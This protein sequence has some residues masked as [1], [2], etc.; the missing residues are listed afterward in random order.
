LRERLDN[1]ALDA[2]QRLVRAAAPRPAVENIV[3]VGI[4]EETERRFPE[5]LALWHRH[6]GEALVAMASANPKLIAL[7]IVLPERSY[8]SLVPGLD[9]ELVRGLVA[10]KHAG[11]LV[12]G[13]RL[14][15]QGKPQVV[16]NLLLAAAGQEAMGLAYVTVD[17]D[18]TARRLKQVHTTTHDAKLPL[19]AQ[20]VASAIGLQTRDGIIDFACGKSF[21]YLPM[22]D[23]ISWVREQPLRLST[24]LEGKVVLLGKVG[25]D[26]DPVRQPLS[27]ADWAPN[28]AAPPGVVLIA[29]TLR[30]LESGRILTELSQP[31][32]AALVG[33]SASVVLVGGLWRTWTAAALMT[34]GIA[35]LVYWAYLNGIFAPPTSALVAVGLGGTVRSIIEGVEQRRARLAVE[36]QFGGY[37]SQNLLEAIL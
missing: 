4:D 8:D 7:D 25:P 17:R 36:R 14:D 28:A 5:P 29:Q 22:H 26:D 1:A 35:V 24:M 31:A 13:L 27:L 18:N 16:N 12:L 11:G 32:L 34:V 37:V 15:G 6:L 20:R 3:I 33:L 2:T 10:A 9:A 19:L 23:V 21:S 30:A